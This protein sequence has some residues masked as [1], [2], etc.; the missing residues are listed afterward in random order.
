MDM[1]YPI[2]LTQNY[3]I[4][5]QIGAGGG[6]TVFRGLHKNMKKIVVIKKLKGV[7]SG[8]INSRTEVD[9]LKNLHHSYLPQVFDFIDSSDG[10]FTVMD[11]IEGKSL[12]NMLD[13]N[14]RFTE[15]EIIKYTKQLCEALEYLHSQEPPI[16]H[17][18]IKPDNI[19]ITPKGNVCLIDF[20]I[21]GA[22]EGTGAITFGYTPGY[23][24]P[25]QVE[26]FERLK[27]QMM[28]EP[29][30][31]KD[32]KKSKKN[33]DTKKVKPQRSGERKLVV[34]EDKK[35]LPGED[36]DRTV[37]MEEDTD[38]TVLL[39]EDGDKTV[40]LEEDND[41]TV[42]LED[43]S[44]KTVILE[45]DEDR[46]V[47]LDEEGH[48]TVFLDADRTVLLSENATEI[49]TEQKQAWEES[50]AARATGRT[51]SNSGTS[52][53]KK[54]EGITID[55]RSDIYSLGATVYMLLTGEL[56]N[57][58][59]RRLVLPEVS[60]GFT[61]ILAKALSYAPDKRYQDAGKML[62]AINSVHKKDKKYTNLIRRQHMTLL[63]LLFMTAASMYCIYLGANM[64]T[65]EKAEKYNA[66]VE[67]MRQVT[68]QGQSL[69][70]FDEVYVKATTMFPTN[71]GAYYE[72]ALYLYDQQG[73]ENTMKY[74]DDVLG[75]TLTEDDEIRSNLYYLY[76]DC[77][78]QME[79]YVNA[80]FYY[81]RA[82]KFNTT[83]EEIYRDHA[84]A[85]AYLGEH[86][87]AEN[88]LKIAT[89]YGLGKADIY[90]VQG[91]VARLSGNREQALEYFAQVIETTTDNDLK[92]RAYVIAS[93][94]FEV[95]G[96]EKALLED[97]QWLTTALRELE[98]S[99]RILIYERLIQDYITLGEITKDF[100]YYDL[101]IDTMEE[102]ISMN[103]D[104]YQ[105]YSNAVILCQRMGDLD[106]ATLWTGQMKQ[107][108][109]EHYATYIRLCYLELEKQEQKGN[110]EAS[111]D[112]FAEYYQKAKTLYEA[113]KSGSVTNAELLQLE[114]TYQ[115]LVN[116]GW[117]K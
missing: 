38:K 105:T 117:L 32:K 111:Y 112:Q 9:I 58:K 2:E 89:S 85:L 49:T 91:E 100:S 43:D 113:Q 106:E 109:P 70:T 23:S 60:S 102:T 17:G 96:S 115:Q 39:E 28:G 95:I 50:A 30:P 83:N 116:G 11:F 84:I 76:G 69:E 88:I 87:E 101:A 25:E 8:S 40:L 34:Q 10:I 79:D 1:D 73:P 114:Q 78:F 37:L 72:R 80:D 107:K 35:V 14:Y 45:D 92:Q 99:S 62:Q 65:D 104:T 63:T 33:K 21:S 36:S 54:L 53:K 59:D 20:N 31:G 86:A 68:E 42:L 4:Y 81:E 24:A 3:E 15:Q 57:P 61:V 108:Y 90:M 27:R 110:R 64:M 22:M 44:D 52:G 13:E 71:M 98:L 97:V 47:L 56:R 7:A 75:F 5:E 6:G 26:A 19:M 12:Q 77:C 93:K 16:I 48:K 74:I 94:T 51:T 103:W 46:T 55:K 18:D 82:I 29:E 67:Q 41:K 66:L